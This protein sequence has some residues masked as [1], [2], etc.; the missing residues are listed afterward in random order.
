[1]KLRLVREEDIPEML[2]IY[3]QYIHTP[4]T[5]EYEMPT[6]KEFSQ[7]IL[8]ICTEYPCLICEDSGKIAGYAYAHKVRERAAYNWA[9]ELS[10]YLDF[11]SVSHGIGRIMY[12]GLMEELKLQGI[13]TV[14]GCVTSPNPASEG[15]HWSLGFR[16][17][18]VWRNVGFKDGKW[19]DVLWYEKRIADYEESPAPVIPFPKVD[20]H[21]VEAAL[22]QFN[23]GG[24]GILS[25]SI[26]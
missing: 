26:E 14:Y 9:A 21:R 2:K 22:E 13:K 17:A 24:T 10:I 12:Q 8:K 3:G 4:I 16:P 18:G 25:Y 23:R 7:R 11:E 6:L 20:K 5:F 1:M 19:H 15:L